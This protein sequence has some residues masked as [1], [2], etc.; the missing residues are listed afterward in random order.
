M[1]TIITMAVIMTLIQLNDGGDTENDD[2]VDNE[3]MVILGKF[4]D[5]PDP[6]DR[7]DNA[8]LCG[9]CNEMHPPPPPPQI[10]K[11]NNFV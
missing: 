5:K 2:N 10:K 6:Y 1:K 4:D 8:E 11:Y 9:Q 7:D 3:E